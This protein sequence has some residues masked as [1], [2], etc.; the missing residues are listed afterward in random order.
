MKIRHSFAFF[1][2]AIFLGACNKQNEI[3]EYRVLKFGDEPQIDLT[4]NGSSFYPKKF[5]DPTAELNRLG[6]EG[7]ELVSTYTTVETKF[8]NF[9]NGKY[10]TGIRDN[11]YTGQICFVLK[12][13][14]DPDKTK[15][16]ASAKTAIETVETVVEI[17]DSI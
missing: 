11:T 6:T 5:D 7:W 4:L 2:V 15:T 16:D 17:E 9:G 13:K 12:R 14:A 10:V 1:L 3:W 8:P